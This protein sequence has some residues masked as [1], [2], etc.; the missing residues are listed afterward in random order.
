MNKVN[1]RLTE[2]VIAQRQ[3]TSPASH[4]TPPFYH[5]ERQ[6][7]RTEAPEAPRTPL[8]PQWDGTGGS[9]GQL[10]LD[11]V[12]QPPQRDVDLARRLLILEGPDVVRDLGDDVASQPE[13]IV[14][15]QVGGEVAH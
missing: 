2:T 13:S 9:V 15:G 10:G 12:D 7:T 4:H 8:G 3:A 14:D 11:T 6:V 5:H 1:R